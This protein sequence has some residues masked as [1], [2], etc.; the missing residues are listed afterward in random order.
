MF[1]LI[2]DYIRLLMLTLIPI[3]QVL[4]HAFAVGGAHVMDFSLCV[5]TCTVATNAFLHQQM[6]GVL[7]SANSSLV[8]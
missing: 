1:L 4:L 7:V 8:D 2:S 3:E 6:G 5:I